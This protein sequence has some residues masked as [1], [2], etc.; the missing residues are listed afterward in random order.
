MHKIKSQISKSQVNINNIF[1]SEMIEKINSLDPYIGANF[2]YA[3]P[4]S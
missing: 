2:L 4:T 3:P 1:S